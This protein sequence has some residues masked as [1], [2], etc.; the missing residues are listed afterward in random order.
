MIMGEIKFKAKA[1]NYD[2]MVMPES[3]W[4]E[5]YYYKD[6]CNGEMKSFIKN[7][8]MDWEVDE[9][10]LEVIGLYDDLVTTNTYA[11]MK[12][13]TT[14]CVRQWAL[15]NKVKSIKIDGIRFIELS[16]EEV[17]ERRKNY[18]YE[19]ALNAGILEALKW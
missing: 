2:P 9:D 16:E 10:T 12:G 7:S 15:Q 19:Q 18:K 5:G 6:L 13:V 14:E 3:G 1:K 17:K 11:K 4:V 8:E